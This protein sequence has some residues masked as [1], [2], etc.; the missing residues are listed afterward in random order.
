M[1]W[2]CGVG[3]QAPGLPRAGC[4]TVFL[5]FGW[6]RVLLSES[7]LSCWAAPSW[8]ER[9]GLLFFLLSVPICFSV[10]SFSSA[11]PEIFEAKRKTW[12]SLPRLSLS[13]EATSLFIFLSVLWSLYLFIYL[14][15]CLISYL[16]WEEGNNRGWDV[17]LHP[18]SMDISLN[19]L[20]ELMM[21]REARR[22]AV[23]GV[24][25]GQTRLSD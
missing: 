19:K 25:K 5:Q 17:G 24:A 10:T 12:E 14:Y 3:A 21:D 20:Q 11:Q 9:A 1:L 15:L 4:R 22:A 23:H 18:H 7:I 16:S 6:S 2:L 8:L 13:P